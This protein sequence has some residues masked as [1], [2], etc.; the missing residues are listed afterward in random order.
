MNKIAFIGAGSMA[1]AVFAGL[2]QTNFI[3]KQ[4]IYVSNKENDVRL[5]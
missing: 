2:I 5:E 4:H 3:D 1:E